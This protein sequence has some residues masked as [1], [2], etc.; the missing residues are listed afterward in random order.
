[1]A[2]REVKEKRKRQLGKSKKEEATKAK[3]WRRVLGDAKGANKK[4]KGRRDV[5]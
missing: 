4:K 1:M 2:R 3:R 5:G